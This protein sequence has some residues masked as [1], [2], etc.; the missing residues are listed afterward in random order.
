MQ[1]RANP[2]CKAAGH[3]LQPTKA[4]KRFF[5]CRQCSN[6]VS[7]LTAPRPA[8]ACPK[9]GAHGW[10]KA[11]LLPKARDGQRRDTQLKVTE[12]EIRSLRYA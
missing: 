2:L 4:T 1:E 12:R 5:A 10:E 3:A 7:V 9:C 6:H 11:G 8:E